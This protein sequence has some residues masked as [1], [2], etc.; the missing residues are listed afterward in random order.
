[1]TRSQASSRC[2][3][4]PTAPPQAGSLS[5]RAKRSTSR[6]TTSNEN[7]GAGS[8]V[9]NTTALIPRMSVQIGG[10]VAEKKE[11]FGGKKAAP[12]GKGGKKQEPAEKKPPAKKKASR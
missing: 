6:S 5:G 11:P 2:G 12:F 9:P 3:K 10:Q 8:T 7:N 1:M 4:A